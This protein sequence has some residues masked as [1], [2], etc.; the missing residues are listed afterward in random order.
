MLL[1]SH[2]HNRVA[3]LKATSVAVQQLKHFQAAHSSP[4]C[5]SPVQNQPDLAHL[6]WIVCHLW[7]RAAR[8]QGPNLKEETS[9]CLHMHR[10]ECRAVVITVVPFILP[11]SSY[12]F[13]GSSD[14]TSRAVNSPPRPHRP[15]SSVQSQLAEQQ[16]C[17][18]VTA[19]GKKRT[20]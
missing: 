18:I 8:S 19:S 15:E 1:M 14:L 20:Q 3:A 4:G 11:A 16:S 6:V 13:R 9:R 7:G 12:C 5:L 17:Y 2:F 10:S